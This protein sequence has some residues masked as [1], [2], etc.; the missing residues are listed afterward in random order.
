MEDTQCPSCGIG[1]KSK[2]DRNDDACGRNM[3]WG[4]YLWAALMMWA[5]FMARQLAMMAMAM[6]ATALWMR[7]LFMAATLLMA[8]AT[9]AAEAAEMMRQ[10]A[11]AATLMA[12]ATMREEFHCCNCA[13]QGLDGA[14]AKV[15]VRTCNS[16]MLRRSER[17]GAALPARAAYERLQGDENN[18][19]Q[20]AEEDAQGVALRLRS[21]AG[22]LAARHAA[23]AESSSAANGPNNGSEC[24]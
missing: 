20:A 22:G 4:A 18:A 7:Q 21:R 23:A 10:L 12:A 15:I 2:G 16:C 3:A 14:W 8:F 24:V 1:L 11:M 6:A 19:R 13:K 17:Q 9:F 5:L